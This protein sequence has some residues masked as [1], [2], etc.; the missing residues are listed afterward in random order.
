MTTARSL[1]CP[2]FRHALAILE[3]AR[4]YVGGEG[5]LHHGAAAVGVGGVVLFGGFVP[6]LVTG[7]AVHANLTGGAEAI[8][9]N[10]VLEHAMERLCQT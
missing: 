10:E 6:P 2:S 3:R 8:T 1:T 5:G 7:Y 4:L 9:V